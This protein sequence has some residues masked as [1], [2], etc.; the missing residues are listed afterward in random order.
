MSTVENPFVT[1]ALSKHSIVLALGNVFSLF[2]HN[3]QDKCTVDSLY[4]FTFPPTL[5][6]RMPNPRESC[7]GHFLLRLSIS[8]W[9]AVGSHVIRPIFTSRIHGNLNFVVTSSSFKYCP[10][11]TAIKDKNHVQ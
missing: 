9:L 6:P 11:M 8:S 1:S 7:S 4:F 2:V 10:K 5:K 3:E